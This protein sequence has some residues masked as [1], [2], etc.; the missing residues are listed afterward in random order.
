MTDI[1]DLD[2][3]RESRLKCEP[4]KAEEKSYT[5]SGDAICTACQFE[6]GATKIDAPVQFFEC[7]SCHSHR[8]VFKGP[9]ILPDKALVATCKFCAG[10]IYM[11]TTEGHFCIG[12]GGYFTWDSSPSSA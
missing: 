6:W 3:F 4:E 1:I 9:V 8:A 12:C 2:T 5:L 7:P 11:M 10:Q